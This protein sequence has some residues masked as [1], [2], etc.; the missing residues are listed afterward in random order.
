MLYPVVPDRS[1]TAVPIAHSMANVDV[2]VGWAVAVLTHLPPFRY[3][4]IPMSTMLTIAA[5]NVTPA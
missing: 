2:L 3:T 1:K 4:N 5:I